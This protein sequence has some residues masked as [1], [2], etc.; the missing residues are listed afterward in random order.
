MHLDDGYIYFGEGKYRRLGKQTRCGRRIGEN[1]AYGGKGVF[2]I[3]EDRATEN[4]EDVTCGKCIELYNR[5]HLPYPKGG[6]AKPSG[7][8][9]SWEKPWEEEDKHFL[10]EK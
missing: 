9:A 5:D 7:S 2:R 3:P 1:F 4:R 10:G 8:R 6:R